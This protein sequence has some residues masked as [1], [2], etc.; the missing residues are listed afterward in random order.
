MPRLPPSPAGGL[1]GFAIGCLNAGVGVGRK[2]DEKSEEGA[3]VPALV[4]E[5]VVTDRCKPPARPESLS[6]SR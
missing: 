2:G 4:R 3:L 1:A 5:G 6:M